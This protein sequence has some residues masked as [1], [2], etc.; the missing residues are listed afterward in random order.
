MSDDLLFT[1]FFLCIFLVL[2]AFIAYADLKAMQIPDLYIL[3]IFLT[4]LL[5][6]RCFPEISFA[7]AGFGLLSVSLPMFLIT[8][9]FPGSF[10][11]GDIKLM[12]ACGFFL[13]GNSC[14]LAFIIAIFTSAIYCFCLLFFQKKNRK[15]EFAFGPFLCLGAAI[16]LAVSFFQ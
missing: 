3:L 11:G 5:S 8:W 16:S 10:G 4:R 15:S 13:G 9:I 6:V 2:L 7:Q 12:A 14:V 1:V